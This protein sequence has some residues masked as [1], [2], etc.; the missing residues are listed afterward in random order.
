MARNMTKQ[1]APG[2]SGYGYGTEE[3]MI[4]TQGV[5]PGDIASHYAQSKAA[6]QARLQNPSLSWY[7]GGATNPAMAAAAAGL[8]APGSNPRVSAGYGE[9]G[10]SSIAPT[11]PPIAKPE[12]LPTGAM[13]TQIQGAPG[14]GI[15]G[16]SAIGNNMQQGLPTAE[17]AWA[18]LNP[19]Q[20]ATLNR[21]GGQEV[22]NQDFARYSDAWN[23][24][25]QGTGPDPRM[26]LFGSGGGAPSG[27]AMGTGHFAPSGGIPGGTGTPLTEGG[28]QMPW[29][30]GAP[31]FNERWENWTD[32][33]GELWAIPSLPMAPQPISAA[34]WLP[35]PTEGWMGSIDPGIMAGITEP[36]TDLGNQFMEQLGAQ[37][38]LGNPRAGISGAA[39]RAFADEIA[40]KAATAIP[41]QAWQMLSAPMQQ[42]AMMDYGAIQNQQQ[43]NFQQ[44]MNLYNAQLQR[45]MYPASILPS[46]FGSGVLNPT[47]V[48]TGGGVNP[49]MSG[50]M[51]AGIGATIPGFGGPG[52]LI[53]G[54]LGLIGGLLS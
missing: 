42:E 7:A 48:V 6:R 23:A 5:S 50:M 32:P 35:R 40:A 18:A 2:K 27:G 41:L 49:L 3:W 12:G 10:G 14:L 37:G 30:P 13:P 4:N 11:P 34:G 8:P 16:G 22:F 1:R 45:N 33:G 36:W 28:T 52:A 21:F 15:G 44:A 31:R 47:P 46:I 19:Q 9:I 26:R 51:G 39:G 29:V 53:G 38:Q 54:G 25:Q 24:W 43:Q 17:Q 20:Q